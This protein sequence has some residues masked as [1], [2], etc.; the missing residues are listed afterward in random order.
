MKNGNGH[1]YTI[2]EKVLAQRRAAARAPRLVGRPPK[3]EGEHKNKKHCSH[4]ER[5]PRKLSYA[6]GTIAG[7]W[8]AAKRHC[9]E[10]TPQCVEFWRRVM[11]GE[12]K[13]S[14]VSDRLRAAEAIANRGRL[15]AQTSLEITDAVPP[16][17]IEQPGW[18]D[19]A[20]DF[21]PLEVTGPSREGPPIEK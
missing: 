14:E 2:T 16:K 21:H 13:G 19:P 1:R 5:K 10:L 8:L 15:P 9:E 3:R 20:G 7:D 11:S 6:P 4:P 12:V 18:R 17:L